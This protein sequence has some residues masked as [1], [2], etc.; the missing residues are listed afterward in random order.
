MSSQE[1]HLAVP[2]N[3]HLPNLAGVQPRDVYVGH[4]L[5]R[6]VKRQERDVLPVLLKIICS[7]A[8]DLGWLGPQEEVADRDVVAGKIIY[9]AYILAD[10]AEVSADEI[11]V[12]DATE[13]ASVDLCLQE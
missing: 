2:D 1:R 10:G 4:H 13:L 9:R 7:V 5:V 8:R 3:S 6:V 12:V 11:E